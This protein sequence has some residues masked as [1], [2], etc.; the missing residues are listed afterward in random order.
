MIEKPVYVT[1]S[2]MPSYEEYIEMI[3]PMWDTHRIT[4]MGEFHKRLEN[5]L[6]EFLNIPHISLMVNGHTALEMAIQSMGF[7]KGSEIITTPYTFVSTTHAIIRSGMIPIFCD[8]KLSDFTIDENKIE[9]LIT[10]KTVAIIPV[11]VYGNICN[12]LQIEKIAKRNKLKVIYDAAHSFGETI[13]GISVE[14]LGDAS[15]LS[16]HATKVFNT[17]EG[18]AVCFREEKL[19][20]RLY[21]L[22]NFGIRSEEAVVAVGA[23][24]KMNEFCAVMGLCNLKYIREEIR[25]REEKTLYYD[26]YLSHRKDITL[27][28]RDPKI[29]YNYGYY[30]VLFSSEEQRNAVYKRLA[31]NNIYARKYFY[32]ITSDQ[33][34]F[35]GL[36]T[37][38]DLKNA[39]YVSKRILTLP[40]YSDLDVTEIEKICDLI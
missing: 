36:Y 34:C 39:R 37:E 19:Y 8:I 3:R 16:F 22:K 20:D 17:I 30:P 32:P 27:R 9:S 11:H 14:S 40:M 23:N 31:E 2:S 7:P 38:I 6:K 18:G 25:K 4:N 12:Y 26:G 15:V 13:D 29:V 28:K 10:D 24:G 1:H 5:E 35:R 33:Q 21:N